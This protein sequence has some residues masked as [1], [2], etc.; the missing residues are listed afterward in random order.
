MNKCF[1]F[2]R[3]GI[4][5]FRLIDEYVTDYKDFKFIPSFLELFRI[6]IENDFL[7]ILITNQQGIGKG[8]MTVKDLDHIHKKMQDDLL[9]LTG[10]KFDDIYFAPNLKEENS[11]RRKP[12]PGMLIEAKEKWDIDFKK[13]FFIGDSKSDIDAGFAVG[14]KTIFINQETYNKADFNFMSIDDLV[15]NFNSI[16]E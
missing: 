5:N 11:F 13:S 6:V 14:T 2:D 3:D 1:F 10:S 7:V 4:V 12:N 16:L 9:N 15:Y 8:L